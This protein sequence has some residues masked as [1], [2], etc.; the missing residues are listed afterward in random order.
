[1]IEEEENKKEEKEKKKKPVETCSEG[2]NILGKKI[3]KSKKHSN[4]PKAH[5]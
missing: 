4:T 5:G 2:K 1:M 3:I